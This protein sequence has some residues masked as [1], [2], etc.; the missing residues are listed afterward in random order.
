MAQTSSTTCHLLSLPAELRNWI[1]DL[2]FTADTREGSEVDLITATGP[3]RAILATCHQVQNEAISSYHS[4]IPAW[5]KTTKFTVP[6]QPTEE[7]RTAIKLLDD[8]KLKLVTTLRVRGPE[9]SCNFDN[10]IWSCECRSSNKLMT[11]GHRGGCPR[12]ALKVNTRVI[13]SLVDGGLRLFDGK[14]EVGGGCFGKLRAELAAEA[15]EDAKKHGGW[16]GL[17][18][19]EL[20]S[21]FCWLWW[22]QGS[23]LV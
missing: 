19:V 8:V 22:C 6:R 16:D 15:I 2:A 21:T 23:A 20:L 12:K 11:T 3:S 4:A 1:W 13:D 5:W 14:C 7:K 18:K 17:T 10:G 9:L